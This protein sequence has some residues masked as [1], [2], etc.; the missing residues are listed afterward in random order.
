M[1]K[2]SRQKFKYLVNEKNFQDEI[3][4]IYHHFWRAII[5]ENISRYRLTKFFIEMFE[6]LQCWKSFQTQLLIEKVQLNDR[7]LKTE[8]QTWSFW[9]WEVCLMPEKGKLLNLT[10]YFHFK[11]EV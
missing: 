7:K 4:C 5:E 2:K 11:I 3:K 9:K 10:Q 1:P 6:K 8:V